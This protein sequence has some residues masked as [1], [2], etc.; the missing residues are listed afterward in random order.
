MKYRIV[1][2]IDEFQQIT[3][4]PERNVDAWLRTRIQRLRNICFIFS[5]SQQH[6]IT[7][8]FTSPKRPFFRSTQMLKLEKIDKTVYSKFICSSFKRHGKKIPLKV[9]RSMVDWANTHT[10]Y[11][12]LLAN[13]T[14][15][16]TDVAAGE[17]T[18]KE[19]AHLHLKEQ[20]MFFFS[21]RNMLTKP[22]WKLLKALAHEGITYQ[23]TGKDFLDRYKLGTSATV[24]R[25]LSTL[26]K[27]ELAYKEYD[28]DGKLYYS[29]Y[30][31][32]M[33]RW[34]ETSLSI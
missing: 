33:Q 34:A 31:V 14:F 13:R 29:V 5:G 6:L 1:I 19:Q 30:D 12:Q 3:S 25:S 16:A 27:Y 15:S 23:P 10:F 11:V 32:F 17:E 4:Y 28:T 8:L 2:A 21:Q 18:W 20:E 7:E 24:L 26:L 9:A 22:Q